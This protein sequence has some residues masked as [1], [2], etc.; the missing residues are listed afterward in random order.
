MALTEIAVL[1]GRLAVC[2]TPK[3]IYNIGIPLSMESLKAQDLKTKKLL[4]TRSLRENIREVYL[5][6][7]RV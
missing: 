6:P 2:E 4:M 3:Y 1:N 7:E 5:W